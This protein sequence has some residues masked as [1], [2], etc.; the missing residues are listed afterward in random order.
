MYIA[1]SFLVLLTGG[2]LGLREWL[3]RHEV[4]QRYREPFD[5]VMY[6]VGNAVVA[7]RDCESP[8]ATVIGMHGFCENFSYFTDLYN[9]PDVQLILVN[10]GDYHVPLD[11]PHYV[12]ASWAETP[13][14][15]VGSIE[16]DAEVL[17][18]ALAHL[19]KSQ[20]IRVHGHSRGGA[21]VL[22][23]A[24]RRPDLFADVEAILE[25]PVLPQAAP[26]KGLPPGTFLLLPFFVPLWRKQPISARNRALWG[27]VDT[28]RKRA[29]IESLPFN[30]KRTRTLSTNLRLI[31]EWMR[32]RDYG[33]YQHLQRGVIL[34]PEKDKVLSR[35]LMQKA[36]SRR[37]FWS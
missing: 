13:D 28:P 2:L 33:I 26:K 20:R 15:P 16:Y 17:I 7:V 1:L 22:E 12:D 3:L 11:Q 21:V 8:R 32:Q 30:P 14:A 19:P 6:P 4:P 35:Y 18:Q 10:S 34:I 24:S 31:G 25:A 5:G 29:Q 9:D 37:L 23:A 36:P 27:P